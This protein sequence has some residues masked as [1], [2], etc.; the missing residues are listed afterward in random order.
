M[1]SEIYQRNSEYFLM[2][3]KLFRKLK[4]EKK[5]TRVQIKKIE[6]KLTAMS[7]WLLLNTERNNQNPTIIKGRLQLCLSNLNKLNARS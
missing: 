2:A 3:D 6:K 5:L 1:N 4:R 7:F